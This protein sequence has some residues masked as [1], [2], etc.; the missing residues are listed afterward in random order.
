MDVPL[1][2]RSVAELREQAMAYRRMAETAHVLDIRARLVKIAARFDAL[3]DQREQ[4]ELS[5][6]EP[7][8]RLGRRVG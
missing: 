4:Q 7:S 6:A 5:P 2:Q 3:A 1:S 8:S